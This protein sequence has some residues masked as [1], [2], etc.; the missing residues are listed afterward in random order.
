MKVKKEYW[1]LALLI[2]GLSLY[3]VFHRQDRTQY[4]MPVLQ[5]VPA[6][7][8]TRMEIL[9]PG[10]SPLALERILPV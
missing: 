3:L 7:E 10:G 2:I 6:S 1:I 5:E 9:K 4:E 8:I